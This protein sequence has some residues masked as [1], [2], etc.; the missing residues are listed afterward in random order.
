[1]RVDIRLRLG[2][3]ET[4]YDGHILRSANGNFLAIVGKRT[5]RV[6][7]SQ[8]LYVVELF[9][10]RSCFQEVLIEWD[11]LSALEALIDRAR[12]EV[13][14]SQFPICESTSSSTLGLVSSDDY[15]M[16][17]NTAVMVTLQVSQPC[18][19]TI[20]FEPNQSTLLNKG[21]AISRSL[22]TPNRGKTNVWV[23]NTIRI[24]QLLPREMLVAFI[25][26]LCSCSRGSRPL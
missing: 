5:S 12:G 13:L 8:H 2:E 11:S 26:T 3:V 10:V 21:I 4:P 17:P 9:I 23:V 20:I 25:V 24:F 1:M 19:D 18:N 15:V 22:V 7:F 6:N 16:P 14:F